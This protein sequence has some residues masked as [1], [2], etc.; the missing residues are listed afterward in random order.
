MNILML[1]SSYPKYVG[2]TTAPFIESI[3]IGLVRRQ[4]T[5]QVVAPF[6]PHVRRA[7]VEHGVQL[8]FY[9]YAPHPALN[10]YG[11]AESLRADVGLRRTA[12][13]AVPFALTASLQAL[14]HLTRRQRFDL[15]HAHWVLPNGAPAMLAARLCNLPLV[16]SLHG[17]DVFLAQKGWPLALSAAAIFRSAGAITACSSDL[18][19]RALRLGAPPARTTVIPYGVDAHTFRPDPRAGAWVRSELNLSADTPLILAMGR[20]VY[21]KGFTYLLEAMPRIRAALPQATLI[22]AGYGDLLE[23]LK[24]R[25][26][27]A[28]VE[29]AV[30][31]PGQLP[32][33]RAARYVAAADVYVV[34]SV[35]DDSGNVD[36]LPNTL[37]EGMGAARPIVATRTAGIPD[38]ITDGVHGLLVPERDP[39]ALAEA[40]IRLLTERDTATRLG[41]AARRRVLG[42]LSWDVT[43]ERFEE[44]YR[45]AVERGNVER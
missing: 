44:V 32:R 11:Y 33:D 13:A 21:K 39:L 10:V 8:H 38:V 43:A 26:R 35:R 42:E 7:P 25:A 37:L 41:E 3:A 23:D 2:E 19:Q 20:M 18:Y 24:D 34:P 5:V 16:V 40:I 45:R 6:H 14:L 36:G 17:S 12:L 30:L 1:T 28:G 29:D 22:L 15:I 4:H 31:F 27:Q 9:R